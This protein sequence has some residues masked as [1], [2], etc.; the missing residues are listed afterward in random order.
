MV[1]YLGCIR[2]GKSYQ[3]QGT[4]SEGAVLPT[5][6][7]SSGLAFSLLHRVLAWLSALGT[8]GRLSTMDAFCKVL[9]LI[10]LALWLHISQLKTLSRFPAWTVFQPVTGIGVIGSDPY[11]FS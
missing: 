7:S 4:V 6:S 3:T 11:S 2:L 8:N 5:S 9:F 10:V 1:A